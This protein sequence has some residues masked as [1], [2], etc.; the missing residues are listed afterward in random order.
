[1]DNIDQDLP[2]V[3]ILSRSHSRL[4]NTA[5]LPSTDISSAG[6]HGDSRSHR[7]V[8]F[9]TNNAARIGETQPLLLT[10]MDSD[11]E[12]DNSFDDPEF[13]SI[14][15]DVEKAIDQEIYPERISQGSS[16]SYFV[17]DTKRVKAQFYLY[18]MTLYIGP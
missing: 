18:L 12:D 13:Q 1:M 10:R 9:N 14:I 2:D 11:A 16:G 6:G 4:S 3:R 8:Q 15:K 5:A 17:R 7:L